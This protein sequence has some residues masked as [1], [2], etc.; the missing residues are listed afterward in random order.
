MRRGY[1]SSNDHRRRSRGMKRR[2]LLLIS[3][4]VSLGLAEAALRALSLG[5]T[6]EATDYV[7][8]LRTQHADLDLAVGRAEIDSADPVVR[9]RTDA[10]G[11]VEPVGLPAPPD[12][13]IAFVGGSTTECRAVREDLRFPA[14]VAKIFKD[15]GARVETLNAGRSASTVHDLLYVLLDRVAQDDADLVLLME[16]A[17]DSGVLARDGGYA[18]RT[19]AAVSVRDMAKWT[20]QLASQHIAVAEF[21]RSRLLP[22]L[23]M[24]LE[25]PWPAASELTRPAP[26]EPYRERVE[27]FVALARALR[28]EPWL[29]TQPLGY[30]NAT[31]PSW[32]DAKDQA[33]F[34]DELRSVAAAQNVPLIDLAARVAAHPDAKKPGALFYDGLHV[35]DKGSRFYAEVIAEA[36]AERVPDAAAEEAPATEPATEPAPSVEAE[37]PPEG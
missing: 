18:G 6:R 34:N 29:V 26:R 37:P 22:A 5:P 23:R 13:R 28:I 31:T 30:V 10:R 24:N 35:T 3:L 2:W 36:L 11:Y 8:R 12:I 14:L 1:P 20:L 32:V 16:A 25:R 15:R 17:N 9:F 7:L 27:A 19:G 4:L 21:F 33:A